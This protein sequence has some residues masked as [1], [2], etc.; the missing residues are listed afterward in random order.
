[1]TRS[2]RSRRIRLNPDVLLQV[3]AFYS[4]VV[5]RPAIVQCASADDILARLLRCH[6]KGC[7]NPNPI[8]NPGGLDKMKNF[9]LLAY[10]HRNGWLYTSLHHLTPS[11]GLRSMSHSYLYCNGFI[12]S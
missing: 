6:A 11:Q 12:L 9:G 4:R 3:Y 1:M 10:N 2:R 7:R 8:P 5:Q